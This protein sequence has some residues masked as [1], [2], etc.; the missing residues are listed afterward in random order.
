M[1]DLEREGSYTESLSQWARNST[2]KHLNMEH[3]SLDASLFASPPHG[4][5]VCCSPLATCFTFKRKFALKFQLHGEDSQFY[6]FCRK[7]YLQFSSSIVIPYEKKKSNNF[8]VLIHYPTLLWDSFPWFSPSMTIHQQTSH[9]RSIH[10]HNSFCPTG[11]VTWLSDA[12]SSKTG[13]V[14]DG[15][16]TGKVGRKAQ[17]HEQIVW[18]GHQCFLLL[19]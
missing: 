8:F 18:P 12:Q 2:D 9:D 5:E 16:F 17:G 11:F 15:G 3:Q 19:L 1:E 6:K 10:A 7:E 4:K 14:A 13:T